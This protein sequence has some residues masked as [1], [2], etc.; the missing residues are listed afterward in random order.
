MLWRRPF[1]C[2]SVNIPIYERV[3]VQDVVV[4]GDLSSAIGGVWSCGHSVMLVVLSVFTTISRWSKARGF[5]PLG[6]QCTLWG[7]QPQGTRFGAAKYSL[8]WGPTNGCLQSQ[9]TGFGTVNAL[10]G[11]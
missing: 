2:G 9:G 5:S 6:R 3:V 10:T 4:S 1:S 7:V 11:L 8:D